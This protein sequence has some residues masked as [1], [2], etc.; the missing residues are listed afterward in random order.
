MRRLKDWLTRSDWD[1]D[2]QRAMV[3]LVLAGLGGFL[4][5]LLIIFSLRTHNVP[6]V[7]QG[8]TLVAFAVVV[9]LWRPGR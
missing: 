1:T 5:F 3:S 8:V 7:V 2:V 6:G 9:I 4:G